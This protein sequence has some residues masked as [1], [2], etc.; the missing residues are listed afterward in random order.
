MNSRA[1]RAKHNPIGSSAQRLD[2]YDNR[3][4][5]QP[6]GRCSLAQGFGSRLAGQAQKLVHGYAPFS[7]QLFPLIS[8][9]ICFMLI[10]LEMVEIKSGEI[11]GKS[12]RLSGAYPRRPV[13]VS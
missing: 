2:L 5:Q 12:W 4:K 8:S 9:D 6:S 11:G 1:R 13:M 3:H 7:R 10:P